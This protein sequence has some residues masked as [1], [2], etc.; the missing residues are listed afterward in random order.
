MNKENLYTKD[1]IRTYSGKYFNVSKPDI[2]LIDI[3]D[4]AHALS[5]NQRFGG[6]LEQVYSVAEHCLY[7]VSLIENPENRLA[8]L[9]H[10]ASEAYLLDIPTPVKTQIREYYNFENRIMHLIAE[11][12]GFQ[13]PLHEEVKEV[14]KIMLEA[15]WECLML[16]R[17]N[18]TTPYFVEKS[19]QLAKSL[20]L[21]KYTELTIVNNS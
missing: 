2:D 17:D 13:F 6:H 16:K 11:K 15:E 8:A 14:D 19:P 5:R 20:F 9:L 18:P 1:C 10:D 7:C 4:I 12:F 3:E 21:S